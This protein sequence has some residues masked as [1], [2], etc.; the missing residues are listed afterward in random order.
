MKKFCQRFQ[1]AEAVL[2]FC[3]F[4]EPWQKPTKI[5][6]NFWPLQQLSKRC[7][8]QGGLCSMSHQ[9]HV[10]L[11]GTDDAGNFLTLKAQPYPW[12]LAA[13]VARLVAGA[14]P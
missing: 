7:Q 11:S 6:G 9:P 1:P 13:N 3:Q 2:D 4:G 12:A 8:P 14:I 10:H 5:L